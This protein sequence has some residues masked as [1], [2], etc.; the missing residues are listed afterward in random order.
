MIRNKNHPRAYSDGYVLEHIIVAEKMLGRPLLPGECVHHINHIKTD[1][2]QENLMVYASASDHMKMEKHHIKGS[3]N[4]C[5]ICGGKYHAKGLCR[6]H[7]F[8]NWYRI[9]PEK[10]KA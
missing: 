8:Q 6:K 10:R 2:R 1:N 5:S 7:Y 9:H 4:D 3:R